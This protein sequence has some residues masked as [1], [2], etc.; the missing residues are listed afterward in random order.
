MMRTAADCLAATSASSP[1][2]H[3]A[4]DRRLYGVRANLVEAMAFAWLARQ[5]NAPLPGDSARSYGAR[6]RRIMGAVIRADRQ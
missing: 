6:G 3:R 2:R 5:T 1:R 4:A